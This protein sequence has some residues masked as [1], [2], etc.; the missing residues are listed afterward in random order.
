MVIVGQRSDYLVITLDI[1]HA[2]SNWLP[3]QTEAAC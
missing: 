1:L 2:H 3:Y